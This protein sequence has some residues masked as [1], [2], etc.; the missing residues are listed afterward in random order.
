MEI[1]YIGDFVNNKF[2]GKGYDNK[3]NLVLEIEKS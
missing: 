3:G 1:N 2:E